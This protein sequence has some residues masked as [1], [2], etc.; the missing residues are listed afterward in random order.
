MCYN[1]GME[2]NVLPVTIRVFKEGTSKQVPYVAYSPDFDLSAAGK[3]Q[4]AA[5]SALVGIIKDLLDE[6]TKENKIDG[7]LKELGFSKA[8][9]SHWQAPEVSL[10]PIHFT[11]GKADG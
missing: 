10:V 2:A 9:R 6:K 8:K 5:R 7:L 1:S 3:D 4:H 11:V